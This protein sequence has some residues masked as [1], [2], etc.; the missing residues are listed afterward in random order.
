MPLFDMHCHLASGADVDEAV[1]VLAE[2]GGGAL[3]VTVSP[4]DYVT[5]L[6]TLHIETP[7][8]ASEKRARAA[9]G[10]RRGSPSTRVRLA[11][12]LHPWWLADGTCDEGDVSRLLELVGQTDFIGEVGIDFGK[13]HGQHPELQRDAFDRVVE[14]CA[15]QGGKVL[16]IHA[17]K[18]ADTVLD[19]LELHDA[20]ASCTCILHGYSGSTETLWRAIRLGCYF[21][22]GQRLLATRR[23]VEQVR[24]V[25]ADRLL[26]E[27]DEPDAGNTYDVHIATTRLRTTLETLERLRGD[28]LAWQVAE[29][30]ARLLGL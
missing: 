11:A 25:P 7:A 2:R 21:S 14:R 22:V 23:G 30:S 12:G 19:V 6:E 28:A 1:R 24:L 5:A 4:L 20:T 17:V 3:S 15:R 13:R 18:A 29:T 16:S 26:L 8:G 27:T 9:T 10:K